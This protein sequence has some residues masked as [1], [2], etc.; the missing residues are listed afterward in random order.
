MLG[1]FAAP[2]AEDRPWAHWRASETV[3]GFAICSEDMPSGHVVTWW[4]RGES[5]GPM[6]RDGGMHPDPS[7][8]REMAAKRRTVLRRVIANDAPYSASCREEGLAP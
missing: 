2:N 1:V 3:C 7:T 4:E 6:H 8:A 5:I